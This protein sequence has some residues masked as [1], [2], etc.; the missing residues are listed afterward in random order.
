MYQSNGAA[1]DTEFGEPATLPMVIQADDRAGQNEDEVLAAWLRDNFEF[2][3]NPFLATEAERDGFLRR[4]F[5]AI[6]AFSTCLNIGHALVVA[7][8]G[9]GKTAL[10]LALSRHFADSFAAR[11]VLGVSHKVR[12]GRSGMWPADPY[13]TPTDVLESVARRAFVVLSQYGY[14]LPRLTSRPGLSAALA[15]WF[16]IYL[17]VHWRDC[18]RSAMESGSLEQVI[19]ALAIGFEYDPAAP[20]L[21]AGTVS[22]TWLGTW[23]ALLDDA[24]CDPDPRFSPQRDADEP[25]HDLETFINLLVEVGI[26]EVIVGVDGFDPFSGGNPAQVVKRFFAPYRGLL[27]P[28]C[29]VPHLYFKVFLPD[30]GERRGVFLRN[31]EVPDGVEIV[32]LRWGRAQFRALLRARLSLASGGVIRSLNQML[33]D[34]RR[35][36]DRLV[37]DGG[38]SGSGRHIARA[39]T[40]RQLLDSARMVLVERITRDRRPGMLGESKFDPQSRRLEEP[41]RADRPRTAPR[42]RLPV[43]A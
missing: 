34:S 38:F 29:A 4:H 33:S 19:V 20:P 10:M 13:R 36:C 43:L 41:H 25:R 39:Q 32:D 27:D 21:A 24:G 40:P 1:I 3:E 9:S 11:K 35:D 2:T 8:P 14:E 26:R 37:I 31:L 22:R 16:D 23:L 18:L 12:V 6:P 17:G 15:T 28:P 30:D 5:L 7:A 42:T